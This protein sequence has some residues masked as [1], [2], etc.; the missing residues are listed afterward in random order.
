MILGS[1][2]IGLETAPR[3][4]RRLSEEDLELYL[5]RRARGE[6]RDP[7]GAFRD[8]PTSD[9]IAELRG[10][11]KVIYRVYLT[12]HTHGENAYVRAARKVVYATKGGRVDVQSAHFKSSTPS[13]FRATWKSVV[14]GVS[15][16]LGIAQ[17]RRP[18]ESPEDGLRAVKDELRQ[19]I[20]VVKGR[21]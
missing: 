13:F 15:Q 9:V 18:V 20:E 12:S 3:G 14:R 19:A 6:A 1:P 21:G 2:E 8:M 4:I 17:V 5:S 16:T 10:D 11:E 7:L